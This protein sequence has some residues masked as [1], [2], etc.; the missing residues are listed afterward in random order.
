MLLVIVDLHAQVQ[1]STH[2]PQDGNQMTVE[3]LPTWKIVHYA[4]KALSVQVGLPLLEE[5]RLEL[6]PQVSG[7]FLEQKTVVNYSTSLEVNM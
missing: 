3:P 6:D 1:I 4:T 5:I 2:A 7:R